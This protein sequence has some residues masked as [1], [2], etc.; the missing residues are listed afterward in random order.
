MD[1]KLSDPPLEPV[2]NHPI[3]V[4]VR[5]TGLTPDVLRVWERRHGAVHPS[6]STGRQRLYTEADISRLSLLGQLTRRGHRIGEIA[7]LSEEE[8]RGLVREDAAAQVPAAAA[9]PSE[10]EQ[11]QVAAALACIEELDGPGLER[12]VMSAAV[13]SGSGRLLDGLVFPLLRQ[14]GERWAA[15]LLRPSHEHLATTVVRRALSE[16][17]SRLPANPDAPVAL[18]STPSGHRHELGALGAAI[19]SA[20]LG[21]RVVY[22]GADV[23]ADDIASAARELGA[24]LVGLSLACDAARVATCEEI[25]R[26]AETLPETTELVVGGQGAGVWARDLSASGATVMADLA[27]FRE[28]LAK[29]KSDRK[30]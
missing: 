29:L 15:G 23:P 30:A 7:R 21:W 13:V 9:P 25:R 10:Y 24:S 11:E 1:T 27:A 17:L 5:R 8:L 6:R 18:F 12:I 26:V 2:V 19:A 14:I 22:L 4:V 28:L 3:Q 16:C 20:G